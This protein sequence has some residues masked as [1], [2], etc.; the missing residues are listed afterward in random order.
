MRHALLVSVLLGACEPST[1]NP[2]QQDAAAVDDSR[3]QD[4]GVDSSMIDGATPVE[5][6]C[7]IPSTARHAW[8]LDIPVD[9]FVK[10]Q[11]EILYTLDE[12]SLLL[13]TAYTRVAYCLQLDTTFMYVEVDDFTDG[14]I[15]GTGIPTESVFETPVTNLTL[16]TNHPDIGNVTNVAGGSIELWPN[17]Y[18]TG[19]N[20]TYDYDD[21][22]S[23]TDCYGSFQIHLETTTLLAYNQWASGGPDDVGIGNQ[24]AN[25]PDWTFASN[26]GAFTT[27]KLQAFVIP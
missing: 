19:A 2:L 8:T 6:A 24:P 11:A 7:A 17:C 21:D 5:S 20:G 3:R 16:R 4:G 27:R 14:Q 15:A 1:E 9:A 23:G 26:A 22:V 18:G 25:N 13:S 12:R 10:T